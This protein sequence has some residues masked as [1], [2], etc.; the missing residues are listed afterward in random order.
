MKVTVRREVTITVE[1]TAVVDVPD[2]GWLDTVAGQ[3]FLDVVVDVDERLVDV[4]DAGPWGTAGVEAAVD[5]ADVDRG[6]QLVSGVL[7]PAVPDRPGGLAAS[8]PAAGPPTTD[9]DDDVPHRFVTAPSPD[10]PQPPVE[11]PKPDED[12]A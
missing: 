10:V 12:A 2:P 3:D 1:Q 7:L 6:P 8:H 11:L 5:D 9:P 4:I